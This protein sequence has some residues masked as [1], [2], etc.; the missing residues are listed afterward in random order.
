MRY[1]NPLVEGSSPSPVT[2]DRT[3]QQATEHVKTPLFSG[4]VA[5]FTPERSISSSRTEATVNGRER[6]P[7]TTQ[8]TTHR[9][10]D[11]PDLAV[12][13]EAWIGLPDAIRHGIVAMVRAAVRGDFA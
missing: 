11:D 5:H 3:R 1:V 12:V 9:L 8:I 6:P 7:V 2:R 13:V 10:P 4:N